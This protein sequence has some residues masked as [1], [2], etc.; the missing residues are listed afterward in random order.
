MPPAG[1]NSRHYPLI[2]PCASERMQDTTWRFLQNSHNAHTTA[3]F[4]ITG[5]QNATEPAQSRNT[6]DAVSTYDS[7]HRTS[8]VQPSFPQETDS[9]TPAIEPDSPLHDVSSKS[10]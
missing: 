10:Y 1:H 8:N 7:T 2:L 6:R 5:A 9:H 3:A 4:R